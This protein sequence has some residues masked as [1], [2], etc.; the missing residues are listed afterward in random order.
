MFRRLPH[1]REKSNNS[2]QVLVGAKHC[3]RHVLSHQA[4]D[5]P[6]GQALVLLHRPAEEPPSRKKVSWSCEWEVPKLAF[7]TRSEL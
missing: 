1:S 4:H 7:G 6:V 5:H 2:C 3:P